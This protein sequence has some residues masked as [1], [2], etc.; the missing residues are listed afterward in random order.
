MAR[1]RR[2]LFFDLVDLALKLPWWVG[3]V[4][5]LASY[6]LFHSLVGV[7]SARPAANTAVELGHVMQR[8]LVGTLASVLQYLL[9]AGFLLGAAG[10]LFRRRERSQIFER[11]RH[12][13][14]PAVSSLSW[15][16]FEHLVSEAFRR[17]GFNVSS[18]TCAGADGG[19][20]VRATKGSETFLIQC[21]HW[22]AQQ[23]GVGVVRELY[24]VMAAEAAAGGF[25]V[26]SGRFTRDALEFAK[27]RNIELL[28][29]HDLQH[30]IRGSESAQARLAAITN[31]TPMCPSCG[32]EMVRRTARRGPNPGQA[33][34]GCRRYPRCRG[35]RVL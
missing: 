27:G 2:G 16:A 32:G 19:V 25:V 30:F 11:V 10:S 13:G 24:G 6:A 20:D 21:K 8:Q 31:E 14:Q 9:P 5:A 28:D 33:F 4:L 26:T 17:R 29:G 35:T 22:R 7:A 34:L 1:H 23:V 3:V 18:T 15:R 12:Y